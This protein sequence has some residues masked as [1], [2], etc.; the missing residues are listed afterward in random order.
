VRI[1]EKHEAET[2]IIPED[3]RRAVMNPSRSGAPMNS[4]RRRVTGFPGRIIL[5]IAGGLVCALATSAPA[6]AQEERQVIE[7]TLERMVDLTLSTSYQIRRLNLDIQRDQYNLHAQQARLKSSA[8]LDLTVP[9]FR[10]TSEPK[11]NSDLQ[12][13]EIVQENTRRWEG[14]VSIRQPVILLGY[15]TNGYLSLSNRMYRYNQISDDGEQ[16]VNYYNRYYVSYTQPLFQVN[17]LKNDLEG[18]ELDLE[19]SQ[20][21]FYGDVVDI[22]DNVSESYFDLFE[23][24]YRRDIYVD[25]VAN[26]RRALDLSRELAR[27][28][29]T[30]AIEVDQFQVELSNA[31]EYVQSAESDIR[32]ESAGVK[33]DLGLADT[34]SIA[35]S[36]ELFLDPVPIDM[37]QAVQYAMELTP[38]M[39]ELDM[40]LRRS[41]IRLD[42]TKSR[43]GFQMDV[44][45]SYGRERR[46]EEVDRLWVHPDNSYTVDV[47]MEIPVWDWGERDARI[48]A[49]EIGIQQS[50]LRKEET[51]L[52]IVSDVRNE[53]LNVRDRESRTMAMRENLELARGVTETSFQRYREGAITALDLILSLRREADTAE[54]FLDAYLGWR[55]SLRDLQQMTYFDFERGVPVLERF[56]VQDRMPGDGS[57]GLSLPRPPDAAPSR[58]PGAGS[59]R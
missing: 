38:R 3:E 25:L 33:R 18:A 47:N 53:V 36:P 56:G 29:S 37:D 50:L 44:E 59:G 31:Q 30:R 5:L 2:R 9:A 42:F 26:L 21:E 11:W 1:T 49:S 32:L 20:L 8:D 28:D 43:G 12:K 40:S 48:A 52:R 46:D 10:L 58:S 16:D 13:N 22:V 35:I 34:D 51:E 54:N 27:T 6:Q 19:G 7:L 17:E 45:L 14:E 57:L 55:E 4:P 41:E 39:R 23:E 15:P 24:H